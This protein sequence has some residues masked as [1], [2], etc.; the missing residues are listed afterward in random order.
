LNQNYSPRKLVLKALLIIAV[1]LPQLAVGQGYQVNLQGQVQQGMGSAGAAYVQD[2]AILFFNPGGAAFLNEN[3]ASIGMTPTF[4]KATFLEH[5]TKETAN[6][7]SPMGTPFTAYGHF[8]I[9]DSSRLKFGMAI[10]TPFGSTVE[11]EEGWTGRFALTRLELKSIFFQPSVSFRLTDK[12]GIGAGLVYSYGKVNLQKDLPLQFQ[13]GTYASA[14]LAGQGNGFGFNA[15]IYLKPTDFISVGITYKSE[16][17]MKVDNGAA[18]FTV[19]SSVV[20][21]FPSGNFASALPLPQVATLALGVTPNDKLAFALDM[22]YVGWDA[23]D[24]LAFDYETNTESLEDTKSARSYV[25]TIAVR[26]GSQYKF[27]DNITGRLGFGYAV[28]PVT[29][30][31]VTPE[32]PDADRLYYTAGFG[33]SIN[34]HFDLDASFLFTQVNREDTNLETQLS[35]TFKTNVI[36]LGISVTYKF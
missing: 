10:Y 21:K 14:E 1:V 34:D 30:G 36:A 28:S 32:T 23:Y 17:S 2:A 13:D 7:T 4:A 15:G 19:P 29:N 11:W 31:Y 22:N 26:L 8:Q 33:Y 6:T 16:I 25:N 27:T 18:T 24:T 12:I 35:G 9:K 20:D 3:Q 5:N